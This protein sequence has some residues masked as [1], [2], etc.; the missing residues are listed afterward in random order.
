MRAHVLHKVTTRYTL[1][2]GV[3]AIQNPT[4]LSFILITVILLRFPVGNFIKLFSH[5]VQNTHCCQ[6]TKWFFAYVKVIVI[7][8]WCSW[9]RASWYI[10]VVKPIRCTIFRVY[11]VP[12]YMFRTVF[13]SIIRSPILYIQ[14]QVYVIL[15]FHKWAKLQ[16]SIYTHTLNSNFAH[17]WTFSM[18]YTWRSMYGIGLL[19][20]DGKTVRNM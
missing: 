1:S 18:T 16:L 13:L 5:Y 20:M 7:N 4:H 9:D 15:K 12:L 14:R 3:A 10:S 8:F 11:S 17:L 2:C 19:M 6:M